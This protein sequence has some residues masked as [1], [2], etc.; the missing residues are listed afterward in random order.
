MSDRKQSPPRPSTGKQQIV[1][2]CRLTLEPRYGRDADAAL[3]VDL[4]ERLREIVGAQ[5]LSGHLFSV[6]GEW[7]ATFY[8][9]WANKRVRVNGPVHPNKDQAALDGC[10]AL[11]NV[12][13]LQA[14]RDAWATA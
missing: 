5:E 1:G 8:V 11:L 13:W 14:A 7:Y 6:D 3:Q 12:L 9:R 4:L 2:A 10:H